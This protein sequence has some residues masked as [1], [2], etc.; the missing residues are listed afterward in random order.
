M[1]Y[2]ALLLFGVVFV[3]GW[4]FDTLTQ[5]R[6]ALTLRH[7]RQF[8]LFLVLGVYFVF[9]WCRSGQTL[10]MKTWHIKLIAG[11]LSQLPVSK[12]VARY[13]L[14][15]LWFLPAMALA[16]LFELKNWASI[17]VIVIGMVVWAATILLDKERQFLHDRLAGT[18]LI[19]FSPNAADPAS[20]KPGS[21]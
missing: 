8:W 7:T 15:W 18:R 4:L 6:H 20:K 3:A 14:A 5:S 17:V 2:E 11:D 10:A 1:L 16:S 9:F 13:L 19:N 21:L 12:A